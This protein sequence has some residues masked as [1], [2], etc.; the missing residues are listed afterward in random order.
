MR[1][2]TFILLLISFSVT[3]FVGEIN[4]WSPGFS[5]TTKPERV[6]YQ[7]KP[8]N[9]PWR[10][11]ALYPHLKDSYW[12]SVNYGMVEQARE[13]GIQ[14]Q[15]FDAGGYDNYALQ[16]EQLRQ[17][18]DWEA[19]AILLGAVSHDKINDRLPELVGDI[20][21]LGLVNEVSQQNIAARVGV[22]WSEMGHN[23]GQFLAKRSE[24]QPLKVLL[25][26]GPKNRGG[27]SLI[28]KSF[29]QEIANH[30]IQVVD[31]GWGDNDLEVQRNLLQH[32]LEKHPD[33]NL[34]A[35]SAVAI[36]AAIPELQLRKLN[37]KIDLVSFYLSHEVYRGLKRQ[38]ILMANS[39]QMVLQGRLSI[40]Q[41][42][43]LLQKEP[44]LADIGPTILT[45]TPENISKI[46]VNLSLSPG[47]FRPEYEVYSTSVLNK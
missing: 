23:V 24:H 5:Y 27:T 31:I 19:D 44:F 17:C 8:A 47:D 14:L 40:D 36:E 39:D 7:S 3:A 42:I 37:G 34:I 29:N 26:P 33:V 18:A 13:S 28:E 1:L 16:L 45:L 21:V 4:L 30:N 15:V 32:M 22:P 41:A 46:E 38:R 11:C 6:L 20:P 12:L 9:R 25:L 2:F 35:G 43:R 10:L